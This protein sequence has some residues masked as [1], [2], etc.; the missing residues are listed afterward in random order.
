MHEFLLNQ[1]DLYIY[2]VEVSLLM[3]LVAMMGSKA[4][5]EWHLGSMRNISMVP[6]N[7]LSV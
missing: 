7:F 5:C 6:C 2:L 4:N 1:L 3:G